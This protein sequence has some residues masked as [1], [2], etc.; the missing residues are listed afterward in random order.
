MNSVLY[1][2]YPFG[3]IAVLVLVIGLGVYLTRSFNLGWRLFWIGAAL[4]VISQ[5]LHIPFNIFLN[6]LFRDGVLPSPTE[7]GQLIFS[8]LVVGLSS[9]LFE[10]LTRYA[11]LRWWAKE[12][13][14]W[15]RGLL[16]GSGWGG[17]EAI[18]FF[19]LPLSLNF[20]AYSALQTQDLSTLVPPEQLT[21]LQEGLTSFWSVSWYDSLLGAVE[22]IFVLPVQ[23][24]WTILVLQLFIRRQ[25]RW[26]WIAIGMHAL[27]DAAVVLSVSLWGIYATEGIVGIFTIASLGI[28]YAL[29]QEEPVELTQPDDLD[30]QPVP[31]QIN[32][33]PIE[34]NPE[35]IE[36]TRYTD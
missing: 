13:R 15:S 27:L 22:R 7:E 29:R 34:V 25:S 36:Q 19:V 14:S 33:P 18:I 20:I 4:L 21:P 10:E 35:N 8:A 2:T 16:F 1:F 3:I 32:L 26:L 30:E 12:A 31:N 23:I 24:S 5:I 9:G 6:R 28:L 11:G 17:M